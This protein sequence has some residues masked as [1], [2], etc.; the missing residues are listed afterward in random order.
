M[1]LVMVHSEVFK[2]LMTFFS[3]FLTDELC[4]AMCKITTKNNEY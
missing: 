4:F 3:D 2:V 1:M